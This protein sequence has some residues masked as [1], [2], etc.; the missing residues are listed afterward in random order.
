M[1]AEQLRYAIGK[2]DER[3]LEEAEH[4][5]PETRSRKPIWMI[6]SAS[7]AV[8]ALC[9]CIHFHNE[10]ERARNPEID[11]SVVV[12]TAETNSQT[13]EAFT[14][15]SAYYGQIIETMKPV[16]TDDMVETAICQTDVPENT[17]EKVKETV[18]QNKISDATQIPPETKR[19]ETAAPFTENQPVTEINT[20]PEVTKSTDYPPSSVTEITD[21]QISELSVTAIWESL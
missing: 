9:T 21:S 15:T 10:A 12:T 19:P 6:T 1:N 20:E 17:S 4:Y 14:E 13:D 18:S 3:F 7:A 2:I 8:I 5:E 16:C 11:N